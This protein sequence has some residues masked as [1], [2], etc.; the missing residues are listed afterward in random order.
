MRAIVKIDTLNVLRAYFGVVSGA[1][2]RKCAQ[3][4]KPTV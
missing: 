2:R 1:K 3:N 4:K